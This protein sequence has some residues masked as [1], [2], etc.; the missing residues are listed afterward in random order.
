MTVDEPANPPAVEDGRSRVNRTLTVG[1]VIDRLSRLDHSLPVVFDA[2]DEPLGNYGVRD[3]SVVPM[4]RESTHAAEPF[5][6]DVYHDVSD[7]SRQVS[8]YYDEPGPVAL[9]SMNRVRTPTRPPTGD[10]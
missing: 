3:V 2:E 9:L 1:E 10:R 5:G 4:Q 7:G 8:D 6:S